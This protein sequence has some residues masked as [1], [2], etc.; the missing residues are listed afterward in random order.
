MMKKLLSL[1]IVGLF[2]SGSAYATPSNSNNNNNSTNVDVNASAANNNN[3]V[4]HGGEGGIGIGKGGHGGE[5]G[6]ANQSQS[7]T[8]SDSGNSSSVANGGSSNQGQHQQANNAGN[9]Q[10]VNFNTPRQYHNT[11]SMPLFVPSPTATCMATIGGAGA[12]AGFGFSISG[13]YRSMHCEKVELAKTLNQLGQ[14]EAALQVLCNVD[15][16]HLEGVDL[17]E[18]IKEQRAAKVAAR[19]AAKEAQVAKQSESALTKSGSQVVTPDQVNAEVS[20][21]EGKGMFKFDKQANQWVF[22]GGSIFG[23]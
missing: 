6:D 17:C 1:V 11:P 9:A 2:V 16:E 15:S 5:G 10:N 12:G 22:A 13:T 8:L 4:N 14:G 20:T 18:G 23:R 7:Q 21:N 3:N 19:A